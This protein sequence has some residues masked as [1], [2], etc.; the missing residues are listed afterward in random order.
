METIFWSIVIFILRFLENYLVRMGTLTTLTKKVWWAT[1]LDL[2]DESL[3]LL[4]IAILVIDQF[5]LPYS[6]S[7]IVGSATATRCVTMRQPKFIWEMMKNKKKSTYRK[8]VP[9]TTG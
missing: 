5:Y 4:A 1:I 9:F 6:I 3:G 7:S 2:M 8:K